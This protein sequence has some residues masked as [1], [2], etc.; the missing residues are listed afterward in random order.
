[1]HS[2]NLVA[3]ANRRGAPMIR[4]A[5]GG[6]PHP[7]TGRSIFSFSLACLYLDA[8]NCACC[9][10]ALTSPEAAD[11]PVFRAPANAEMQ[12]RR[13][14]CSDRRRP[15][16]SSEGGGCGGGFSSPSYR[17]E[18]RIACPPSHIQGTGSN[19]VQPCSQETR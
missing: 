7:R 14:A 13:K 6:R 19:P 11:W 4:L 10:R 15:Q 18:S 12:P 16:K 8:T 9:K 5:I 1:S 2:T 3:R 17:P